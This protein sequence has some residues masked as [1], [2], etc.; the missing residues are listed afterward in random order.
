VQTPNPW[1]PLIQSTLVHPADHLC[2]IQRAFA[3]FS[4]RYGAH[5]AAGEPDFIETEMEGAGVLDGSLFIRAAC[6]TAD[7]LGWV[8][9]GQKAQE[10]DF[11]GFYDES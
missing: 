9:E 2:K 11:G 6:L 4:E 10:W 5:R 7:A 8:R 1:L 3:H